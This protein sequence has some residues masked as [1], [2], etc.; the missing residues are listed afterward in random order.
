MVAVRYVRR[1]AVFRLVSMPRHRYRAPWRW[2]GLTCESSMRP[3]DRHAKASVDANV[4]SWDI[5]W[6][7]STSELQSLLG[8]IADFALYPDNFFCQSHMSREQRC[9]G[10]LMPQPIG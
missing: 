4:I 5:L 3:L 6:P 10:P 1:G 9:R 8:V 2:N 7:S